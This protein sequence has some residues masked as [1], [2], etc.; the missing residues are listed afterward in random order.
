MKRWHG[1]PLGPSPRVALI[2]NDAIGNYVMATP[3]LAMLRQE[4]EPG[5]LDFYCGSRV[6][7][8]LHRTPYADDTYP[9]HGTSP[10]SVAFDVAAERY[11]LVVNLEASTA[12]KFAAGMLAGP[13][14]YVCGPSVGIGCR[15]DLPFSDDERGALW[16]DKEWVAEDLPE[17]YPFLRSPFIVE[18]FARLAFLKGE[19]A[20]YRVPT[21]DPPGDLPPVLIATAASLPEKLWPHDSWAEVLQWL[22]SRRIEVGLLGAPPKEQRAFWEGDDVESR[23]VSEGLVRDLR[24][25]L[26]LP[27]VAG[28]LRTGRVCFSLDNGIVHLAVAGGA[29]TVGLYR[30]GIHRLWAPPAEKLTVLTPG[31]GNPVSAISVSRA[32][33]ALEQIGVESAV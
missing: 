14:G 2:A 3:L 17:R 1:E 9:L 21:D 23:L 19:L 25:T 16:R 22:K 10:D 6:A 30:H 4:L 29:T 20:P 5:T 15:G 31:Q 32:V 7:E 8:F 13:G 11:N 12:A 27:Q 26:T 18:I 33:E 24:G 28:A